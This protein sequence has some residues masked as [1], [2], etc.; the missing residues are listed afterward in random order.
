MAVTLR[1]ELVTIPAQCLA[2][3][4]KLVGQLAHEAQLIVTREG[5][6]LMTPALSSLPSAADT[7]HQTSAR[8]RQQRLSV[9]E[10][11]TGARG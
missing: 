1:S 4:P 8:A 10:K 11:P 7:G 3:P 9:R 2:L 6:P 5:T